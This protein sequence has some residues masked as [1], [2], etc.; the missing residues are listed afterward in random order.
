M[1]HRVWKDVLYMK[2]CCKK[3]FVT[4]CPRGASFL[5]QALL[6]SQIP[7]TGGKANKAEKGREEKTFP[8]A[9]VLPE[10]Q[11]KKNPD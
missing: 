6:F 1:N 4:V 7:S 8:V 11:T 9:T 5:L 3:D 10:K 2:R